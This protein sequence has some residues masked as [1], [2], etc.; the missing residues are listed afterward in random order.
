LWQLLHSGAVA[1]GLVPE[2]AWQ[3][4]QSLVNVV[5]LAVK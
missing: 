1:V 2:M 4:P 5:A 3:L